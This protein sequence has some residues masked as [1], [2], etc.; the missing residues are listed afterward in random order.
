M[1]KDEDVTPATI[2]AVKV[3]FVSDKDLDAGLASAEFKKAP[4]SKKDKPT[5]PQPWWLASTL[6]ACVRRF[7][8]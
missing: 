6:I 8:V 2:E 3:R 5:P 1:H 4:E 7:T